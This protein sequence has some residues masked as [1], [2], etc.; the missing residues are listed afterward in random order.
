MTQFT[1]FTNLPIYTDPARTA[2]TNTIIADIPLGSVYDQLSTLV[3]HRD[4]TILMLYTKKV[5]DNSRELYIYE[6]ENG[7]WSVSCFD[8]QTKI[9]TIERCDGHWYKRA[10]VNKCGEQLFNTIEEYTPGVSHK[11]YI[12]LGTEFDKELYFDSINQKYV[13]NVT[14]FTAEKM[15]AVA[16]HT[17]N[18]GLQEDYESTNFVCTKDGMANGIEQL[19]LHLEQA[20]SKIL[21]D[22]TA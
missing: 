10:L 15:R 18:V 17:E 4:E 5:L 16:K 13:F 1:K 21:N 2:I 19:I 7:D 9:E 6:G 20:K 8:P 3:S 22:Q 12:S 14:S 11:H